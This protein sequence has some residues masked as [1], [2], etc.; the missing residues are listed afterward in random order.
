V[1]DQTVTVAGQ[2]FYQQFVV[3][4]RERDIAERYAISVHE[5]PSA[6]W[7]SQVWIEY[8]QRRIF[9]AA[10]PAGRTGIRQLG[11]QAAEFAFQKVTDAE[12]ER[13]LF[14]DADVGVDEI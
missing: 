4:W 3:A 6:R 11:E 7:G 2:D 8:A 13:L 1:A 10:L 9:Q 14:R 5:R 12:V